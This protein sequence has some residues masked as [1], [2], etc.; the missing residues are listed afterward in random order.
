MLTAVGFFKAF[1][2]FFDFGRT[3]RPCFMSPLPCL[4]IQA[5][6]VPAK[7]GDATGTSVN[8]CLARSYLSSI[9]LT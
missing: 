4:T 6:D 2:G 3:V 8:L 9:T 5:N 1:F 7:P